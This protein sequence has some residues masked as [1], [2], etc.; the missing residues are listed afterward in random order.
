VKYLVSLLGVS[1]TVGA[2]AVPMP[3]P[4]DYVGKQIVEIDVPDEVT[5][6]QLLA[7][8]LD[9]L[10]CRPS[11]GIGPWV[12]D[13]DDL[14]RIEAMGLTAVPLIHD[15]AAYQAGRNAE[16]LAIRASHGSTRGLDSF[17]DDFRTLPEL[18]GRLDQIILDHSDIATGIMIGTSH[19]GREIRGIVLNAGGG[20][21]PAVLFNGCQHAREW[22]SPMST[23]NIADSLADAYGTNPAITA[24]LDK[25]EVI[26]IPVINPDG[27]EHTYAADGY[28]FWRKNRRDNVGTCEGVDLNR[29]WDADWNGGESTSTDPCSDIYVGP[30][31]MSEPEVAALADYCLAHGNIRAQIDFHAYSQLVLEPRGYTTVPPPDW[32]ELHA[33]GGS[34]SDAI[35]SVHGVNYTHDN[36]CNILYCA[37]GTLIDWPYDSY[38]AL[39]FTIELRPASGDPGGFDPPSS[40]IRPCA[41]E[42]F[43]GVLAL[44]EHVSTTMGIELTAGAP[45]TVSTN[46]AT[47]FPVRIFDR[48]ESPD[49]ATARILYRGDA[50][51]FDEADILHLG[52]ENYEAT[53]PTFMCSESPE[54]YIA[55]DGVSGGMATFPPSAPVDVLTALVASD[56][57]ISF[58][59]NGETNP[60]WVVS[61]TATDGLWDRG[62]PV[63]GGVRGDP[64]VDGDGSGACWLT[65]N[66]A[67][68]SDVD[69]GDTTLTSPVLDSP[70]DGWQ[71]SYWRWFSNDFGGAPNEEVMQILWSEEG[72][73]AWNTLELVGP[74]GASGGWVYQ[75]IDLDATGMTGIES[76]RIRVIAEDEGSGSVVEAGFDGVQLS[77]LDCVDGNPCPADIDADGDVDVDDILLVIGSFGTTGPVGDINEDGTVDVNDVLEVVGGFGPC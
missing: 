27:F 11:P 54:F 45:A 2:I 1:I 31:P 58:D 38:G 74:T 39:S 30:G 69:G 18:N 50:G 34:I 57:A 15:L 48:G 43:A 23:I 67:G 51:S 5:V 40:E 62:E 9:A 46:V 29:N 72:S 25:V 12:V 26:V 36:P 41:E 64:P 17:Y 6:N 3:N 16:R 22:I 19:E 13:D 56:I 20:S 7:D 33:V 53:L 61:G 63:G 24:L 73:S 66:V 68:N 10:A 52:G 42:N 59:D 75:S 65:D 60:G 55:V 71:L 4:A 28:R 47:S 49:P 8:G 32:D 70:G 77:K 44:M 14:A 37:S 76:F 35:A 21:K